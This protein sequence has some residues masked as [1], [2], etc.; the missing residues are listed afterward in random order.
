MRTNKEIASPVVALKLTILDVVIDAEE[1]KNAVTANLPD[2]FVQNNIGDEC[3]LINIR[4]V[5]TDIT[6]KIAPVIYKKHANII[7][8]QKI[9]HVQLLNALYG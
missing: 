5:L 1:S 9:L 3:A 7:N 4:W 8:G 6:M 2:D